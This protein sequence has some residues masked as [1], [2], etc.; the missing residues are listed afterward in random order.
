MFGALRYTLE[1]LVILEDGRFIIIVDSKAFAGI[2]S[3]TRSFC[4]LSLSP[5]PKMRVLKG[6][7]S[8][9]QLVHSILVQSIQDQE[10]THR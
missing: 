9:A 5:I 8:N 3:C 1:A 10:R 6:G 4:I 2:E 7:F